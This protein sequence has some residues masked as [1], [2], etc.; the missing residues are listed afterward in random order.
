MTK[1]E[2]VNSKS[3]VALIPVKVASGRQKSA[4]KVVKKTSSNMLFLLTKYNKS[5]LP[6]K[7][8]KN[9]A[10]RCHVYTTHK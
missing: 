7:Q 9:G 8:F 10:T 3:M 2:S 4:K 6:L 5:P 1:T